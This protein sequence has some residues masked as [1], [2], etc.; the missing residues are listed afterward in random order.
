VSDDPKPRRVFDDRGVSSTLAPLLT[1]AM[2]DEAIEAIWQQGTKVCPHAVHPRHAHRRLSY[3]VD[4]IEVWVRCALCGEM[5]GLG[6]VQEE[7]S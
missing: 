2:L 1:M 6:P 7:R 3:N 4:E 5:I